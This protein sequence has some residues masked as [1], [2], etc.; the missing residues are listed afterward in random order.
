[1]VY[2][3]I[4]VVIISIVTT[5]SQKQFSFLLFHGG[6]AMKVGMIDGEAVQYD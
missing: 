1:M 4:S 6:H 3:L 2:V 5:I